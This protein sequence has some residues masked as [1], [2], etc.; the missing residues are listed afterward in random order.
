[1][2]PIFVGLGEILWD[3]LPDGKQLGG[4]PANFAYHCY[5]LGLD[6][7]NSTIISSIGNDRPGKEILNHFNKHRI[8]IDYLY[9]HNNYKTGSVTVTVDNQGFPEYNIEKNVAWDFIP[10]IPVSFQ[11]T[12]DTVCFGTLAQRAPVSRNSIN[13][14]LSSLPANSVRIFDINLRQSYF[15][16]DIIQKSLNLANIF[17]INDDELKIISKMMKISGSEDHQLKTIAQQYN[18]KLCILTKGHSGSILYADGATSNHPGFKVNIKDT[19]G[20]GDAFTAAIAISINM[21]FEL[22]QMNDCANK[23]AAYVCTCSGATPKLPPELIH[24]FHQ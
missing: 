9:Q 6:N 2:P 18:I 20:A 1:M 22:D 12:V 4:A 19:V 15:S 21:G 10:E 8:N 7:V 17:K 14:F 11:Q 24:L 23:I 5:A 3:M 13:N 16:L